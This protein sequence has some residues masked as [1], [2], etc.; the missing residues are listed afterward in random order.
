M[1]F[2]LTHP[3]IDT[4]MINVSILRCDLTAIYTEENKMLMFEFTWI[5]SLLEQISQNSRNGRN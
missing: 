1:I 5:I 2:I 4:F 3:L